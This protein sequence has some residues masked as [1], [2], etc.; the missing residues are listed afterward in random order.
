DECARAA[1]KA[2][3]DLARAATQLNSFAFERL[4]D[5]VRRH[6]WLRTRREVVRVPPG[7]LIVAA[8]KTDPADQATVI[9][10]NWPYSQPYGRPPRSLAAHPAASAA[11]AARAWLLVDLTKRSIAPNPDGANRGER[12]DP[13]AVARVDSDH[14]HAG[15]AGQPEWPAPP[16]PDSARPGRPSL[17]TGRHRKHR[18]RHDCG[19][20]H[21]TQPQ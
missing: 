11:R 9:A 20:E 21:D 14:D 18:L 2:H 10:P 6:A 4:P 16:P 1:V 12:I 15:R 13:G 3:R 19:R 17:R 5:P 7:A 8:F